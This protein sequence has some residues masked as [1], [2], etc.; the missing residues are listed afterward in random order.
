MSRLFQPFAFV[1][2]YSRVNENK[3]DALST[4]I[5]GRKG[6]TVNASYFVRLGMVF[7]M[8]YTINSRLFALLSGLKF[9]AFISAHSSSAYAIRR[10]ILT[11]FMG[12]Q[13]QTDPLPTNR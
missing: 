4:M 11:L 12:R 7:V 8:N 6:V 10:P 3:F 13:I 9:F 5:A 1:N 2:V